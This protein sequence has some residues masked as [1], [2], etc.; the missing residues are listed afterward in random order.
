M[1]S[2]IGSFKKNR[3]QATVEYVIVLS[4]GAALCFFVY[5]QFLK[6]FGTDL[7][8]K[9]SKAMEEQVFDESNAYRNFP[10]GRPN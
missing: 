10:L 4:V 5:N 8:D 1:K 3:A 6:E 2:T 9:M 7:I